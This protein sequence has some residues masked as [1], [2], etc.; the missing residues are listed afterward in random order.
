[1]L[2]SEPSDGISVIIRKNGSYPEGPTDGVLVKNEYDYDVDDRGL[3]GG[4]TYYYGIIKIDGNELVRY[5]NGVR[6]H[7]PPT[8][9]SATSISEGILVTCN[10]PRGCHTIRMERRSGGIITDYKEFEAD[11]YFVFEDAIDMDPQIEYSYALSAAYPDG[12]TSLPVTVSNHPLDKIPSP[13]FRASVN[14]TDV[15]VDLL[16]RSDVDLFMSETPLDIYRVR[17]TLDELEKIARRIDLIDDGFTM[18]PNSIWYIYPGLRI[19]NRT[20][21][22][23]KGTPVSTF[24]DVEIDSIEREGRNVVISIRLVPE[25]AV[26]VRIKCDSAEDPRDVND[27]ADIYDER[28]KRD[29]LNRVLGNHIKFNMS[30]N[31]YVRIFTEF[32]GGLYS[33]GTMKTIVSE[34]PKIYYSIDAGSRSS[35]ISFSSDDATILSLPRMAIMEGQVTRPYRR[36]GGSRV[37]KT[38]DVIVMKNGHGS[39]KAD[40]VTKANA[41][42]IGLFFDNTDDDKRYTLIYREER[43]CR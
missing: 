20:Y 2:S 33:K 5:P 9:V 42:R 15:K 23:G 13:E 34:T 18:G 3:I 37:L 27:R 7:P 43:R 4:C 28:I 24:E 41:G 35:E 39:I 19:D 10:V 26:A 12:E 38:T 17:L 30:G 6:V 1:M 14:K 36:G 40:C 11:D 32:P 16:A 8:N 29:D 22:M 25:D 31:G 21:L